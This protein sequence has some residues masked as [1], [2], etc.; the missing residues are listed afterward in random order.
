MTEYGVAGQTPVVVARRSSAAGGEPV[1][2]DEATHA[3]SSSSGFSFRVQRDTRVELALVG[4]DYLFGCG[5]ADGL[6]DTCGER[7]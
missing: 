6:T 4:Q 7:S 5:D 2:L 3:F 1:G